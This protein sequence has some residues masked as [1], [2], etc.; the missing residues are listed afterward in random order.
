MDYIKL[1]GAAAVLLLLFALALY[2]IGNG[3]PR[4]DRRQGG[5]LIDARMRQGYTYELPR[6]TAPRALTFG[7][8]EGAY[9][10]WD[11]TS[12]RRTEGGESVAG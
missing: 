2:W 11:R 6:R 12:R 5:K 1:I 4:A 3:G 8:P 7:D 10:T 9:Y